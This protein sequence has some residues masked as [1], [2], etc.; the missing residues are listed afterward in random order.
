[1]SA[2][3]ATTKSKRFPKF[4]KSSLIFSYNTWQE[5]DSLKSCKGVLKD[6][7]KKKQDKA[8]KKKERNRAYNAA[9]RA[10]QK[11]AAV[12]AVVAPYKRKIT[13]LEK[14]VGG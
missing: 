2:G 10:A 9:K 6:W 13:Q 5:P 1:M 8:E 7:E 12:E 14:R 11:A 4:P 3:K